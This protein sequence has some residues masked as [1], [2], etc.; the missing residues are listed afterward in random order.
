MHALSQH[1]EASRLDPLEAHLI[2]GEKGIGDCGALDELAE[3]TNQQIRLEA[4]APNEESAQVA[5]GRSKPPSVSTVRRAL[6][7]APSTA[8]HQSQIAP[9]ADDQIAKR[10]TEQ[11]RLTD[12]ICEINGETKSIQIVPQQEAD[13]NVRGTG[14]LRNARVMEARRDGHIF[15]AAALN[16]FAKL[17]PA[18][19]S[20]GPTLVAAYF[21]SVDSIFE[22]ETRDG[23]T[24]VK[25][26]S[27]AK[28]WADRPY[29]AQFLNDPDA[30]RVY[31]DTRPYVDIAG[32]GI[33]YTKCIPLRPRITFEGIVCGDFVLPAAQVSRLVGVLKTFPILDADLVRFRSEGAGTVQIE[34]EPSSDQVLRRHRRIVEAWHQ[35]QIRDLETDTEVGIDDE[36]E[37]KPAYLVPLGVLSDGIPAAILMEFGGVGPF[38]TRWTLTLT[39]VAFFIIALLAYQSGAGKSRAVAKRENI[40]SRLRSLM[41]GVIET[42]DAN[43]ITAANDRAEELLGR[44][45]PTFGMAPTNTLVKSSDVFDQTAIIALKDE[46]RSLDDWPSG[47]NPFYRLSEQKIERQRYEAMSSRYYVCLNDRNKRWLSITA[48]PVFLPRAT[49]YWWNPTQS[50]AGDSSSSGLD[51]SDLFGT[52]GVIEEVSQRLAKFLSEA[53]ETL[54]RTSPP[55]HPISMARGTLS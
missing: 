10:R 20:T 4:T 12:P 28:L 31:S 48:G 18:K 29:F 15:A 41:I 40:L 22:Y 9:C 49:K 38:G 55:Q 19:V 53:N 34:G 27:S 24:D 8:E 13:A 35:K 42:D 23:K 1:D 47:E 21:V 45:L 36:G 32:H 7:I 17:G 43:N 5:V 16:V 37:T 39:A 33:V 44:A 14:D 11:W 25:G 54:P 26:L 50:S 52:F 46:A 2:C 30:H 51:H 3:R 6:S